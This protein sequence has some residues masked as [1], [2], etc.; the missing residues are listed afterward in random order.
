MSKTV[1][2][3][4]TLDTKGPEFLFLRQKVES[5][6][7]RTLIVDCG[8]M[9]EP[10]FTPDISAAE[11]ARAAGTDLST[12][13]SQADRGQAMAAMCNGVAVVAAALHRQ[14]KLDGIVGMGG[15]AGTTICTSAMRALPLL[16]Q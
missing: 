7:L 8:V 4:G 15:G 3:V 2:I 5:H 16:G 13:V 6:G 14:G 10:H 1:V 9:G 11:V 12:L